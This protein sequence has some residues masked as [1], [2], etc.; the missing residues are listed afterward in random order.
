MIFDTEKFEKMDDDQKLKKIKELMN[1]LADDE[2]W[3]IAGASEEGVFNNY[4][5]NLLSVL[6]LINLLKIDFE[7][8]LHKEND[9]PG[10][11]FPLPDFLIE[12]DMFNEEEIN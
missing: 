4:G 8:Q 10:L 6:G 9:L 11:P 1:E 12:D 2:S 7:R 5:D 3:V